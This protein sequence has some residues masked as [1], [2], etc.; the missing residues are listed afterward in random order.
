MRCVCEHGAGENNLPNCTASAD[1]V[2]DS[3]IRGVSPTNECLSRASNV[4]WRRRQFTT[5]LLLNCFDSF[6]LCLWLGEMSSSLVT[7]L[8]TSLL[9]RTML[10]RNTWRSVWQVGGVRIGRAFFMI[11]ASSVSELASLSGRQSTNCQCANAALCALLLMLVDACFSR[12]LFPSYLPVRQAY[13]NLTPVLISHTNVT[14]T[15][16]INSK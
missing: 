7:R 4:Y 15:L 11:A 8:Y 9:W 13:W 12:L 2:S 16:I 10:M 14:E 3:K 5:T 6:G 1:W